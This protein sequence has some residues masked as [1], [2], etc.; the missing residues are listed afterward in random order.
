MEEFY[1]GNRELT[2][3]HRP[4]RN[5]SGVKRHA[6]VAAL[7]AL[8]QYFLPKRA[9]IKPSPYH[10]IGKIPDKWKRPDQMVYKKKNFRYKG[11]KY[12]ARWK[13]GRRRKSKATYST[14]S[15]TSNNKRYASRKNLG[16]GFPPRMT[17]TLKMYKTIDDVTSEAATHRIGQ[18]NF[19]DMNNDQRTSTVPA[20]NGGSSHWVIG[21]AG[22][23]L[24]IYR[25]PYYFDTLKTLYTEYYITAV[26][27]VTKFFSADT[28]Q[29]DWITVAYKSFKPHDDEL[30]IMRG[31][32]SVELIASQDRIRTFKLAPIN[33]AVTGK[34]TKTIIQTWKPRN[35]I[36]ARVWFGEQNLQDGA[37]GSRFFTDTND[38][39]PQEAAHAPRCIYWAWLS[40]NEAPIQDGALSVETKC[41]YTYTAFG[42]KL[43]AV[44]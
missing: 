6:S 38:V 32:G 3:Y 43:P 39:T 14:R 18:M 16:I 5:Y 22:A 28:E 41:Y 23:A 21:A 13:G 1:G 37:V 44:S 36:P 20:T 9:K 29:E 11:R 15:K 19:N 35:W 12:T 30:E 8:H 24:S 25:T 27:M 40:R 7:S 42:R 17:G 26:K 4:R 10:A 33:A 34:Q 2:T 31:S